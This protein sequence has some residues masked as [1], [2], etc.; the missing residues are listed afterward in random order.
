MSDDV[1]R[2]DIFVHDNTGGEYVV[3]G[4]ARNPET[5]KLVVVYALRNQ[6]DDSFFWRPLQ[7]FRQKFTKK[8]GESTDG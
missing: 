2:W 1:K 4:K 3:V 6:E 7:E 8:R 5:L